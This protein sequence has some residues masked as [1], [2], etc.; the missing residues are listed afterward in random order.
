MHHRPL[1]LDAVHRERR[2]VGPTPPAPRLRFQMM[3]NTGDRVA[4][5]QSVANVLRAFPPLFLR[6]SSGRPVG[7]GLI[8]A[9]TYN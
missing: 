1:P 7:G 8:M 9:Y 5:S 6:Y 2:H 4:S 3:A